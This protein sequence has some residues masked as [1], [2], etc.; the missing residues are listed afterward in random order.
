VS[1]SLIGGGSFSGATATPLGLGVAQ[2]LGLQGGQLIGLPA[3]GREAVPVLVVGDTSDALSRQLISIRGWAA[4]LEVIN[5]GN[6]LRL[7]LQAG[8]GGGIVIETIGI[9]PISGS[10]LTGQVYCER[11]PGPPFTAVATVSQQRAMTGADVN[12]F[13]ASRVQAGQGAFIGNSSPALAASMFNPFQRV[14]LYVPSGAYFGLQ[15][16]APDAG[17]DVRWFLQWRELTG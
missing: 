1:E 8:S 3:A 16:D 5:A 13:P 15:G 11:T 6:V 12:A 2:Q 9:V 14:E 4:R 17:I 10:T 7:Q